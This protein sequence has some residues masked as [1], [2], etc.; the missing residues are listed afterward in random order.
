MSE[1]REAKRQPKAVPIFEGEMPSVSDGIQV[2]VPVR[3]NGHS[4]VDIAIN[5]KVV[6]LKDRQKII[7]LVG[8]GR[9]GK[10]TLAWLLAETALSAERE[11]LLGD[12]V[13]TEET[14][15]LA[16]FFPKNTSKPKARNDAES[17]KRFLSGFVDHV[18]AHGITTLVDMGGGDTAFPSLLSELD[19][20]AEAL[21]SEGI[22]PVLLY[23]AGTSRGDLDP[24]SVVESFGFQP[25]ATAIILSEMSRKAGETFDQAFGPIR[26]QPVYKQ[27]IAR[28]AVELSIP[29]LHASVAGAV[30]GGL[31]L[32][33]ARD[34][35]QLG[36]IMARTYA[37]TWINEELRRLKPIESWLP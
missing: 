8:R 26:R 24:I 23:V 14:F 34:T 37:R 5:G 11:V 9:L 20:L 2:N 19:G 35:N 16:R 21:E 13:P 18:K 32:Y 31:S 28:E 4:R 25:Q 29:V 15:S 33:D 6:D 12:L 17:T 10:T 30:E 22:H 27:L 1:P 3:P 7:F 36:G